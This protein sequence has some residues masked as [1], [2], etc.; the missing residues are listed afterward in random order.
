MEEFSPIRDLSPY[1]REL[2]TEL[3]NRA[4]EH[5][6]DIP[7]TNAPDLYFPDYDNAVGMKMVFTAKALCLACP[8]V[9]LCAEYGIEGNEQYGIWGGLTSNERRLIRSRSQQGRRVAA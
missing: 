2:F 1:A 6:S 8:L 3:T 4:M 7:C 9:A 5:G